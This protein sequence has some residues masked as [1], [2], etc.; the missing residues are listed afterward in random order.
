MEVVSPTAEMKT[1]LGWKVEAVDQNPDMLGFTSSK[2][3]HPN[4]RCPFQVHHLNTLCSQQREA[5]AS[6]L[7]V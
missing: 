7:C 3:N 1:T 2:T 6:E 5:A 4:I